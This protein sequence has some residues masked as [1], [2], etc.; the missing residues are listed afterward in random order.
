MRVMVIVKATKDSEAG[1][2][3]ST[4]FLTEMGRFNEELVKAGVMLSAEGLRSSR[5]ACGS[6]RWR[7]EQRDRW[8][9][10]RDQGADRG[11]LAVAGEARSR[12][13]SMDSSL[14]VPQRERGN[15]NPSVSSRPTI[16]A[17]TWHRSSR[18]AGAPQRALAAKTDPTDTLNN[19]VQAS[20]RPVRICISRA[21]AA[22]PSRF[23]PNPRWPNRVRD[24]LWPDH[25]AAEQTPPNRATRSSHARSSWASQFLLGCDTPSDRYQAP[26]ASTSWPAV[27]EPADGAHFQEARRRRHRDDA[28]PGD[29]LGAPLRHVYRPL[30]Y[31]MDGQLREA[32][33][34]LRRLGLRGA[35][36]GG[37]IRSPWG[38]ELNRTIDALWRIESPRVIAGLVRLVCDVGLA[39]DLAHD[40]LVTALEQWPRAGIPD[41][42]GAWLMATAKNRAIDQLRRRPHARAHHEALG[43]SLRW[44][45]S[46]TADGCQRASRMW[47]AMTCCG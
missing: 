21:T 42:P 1:M 18:A 27:E 2:L 14:A 12:K 4:E 46:T 31:S 24:D 6:L 5:R 43:T 39:E 30:W 28:M 7:H 45:S 23:M 44:S 13:R 37:V 26:R 19:G 33:R 10:Y 9:L 29:F 16:L 34:G 41:N 8:T 25:R 15:R 38:P 20:C 36:S 32:A 47:S 17:R 35:R 22:K 40:A 11:I 3:P